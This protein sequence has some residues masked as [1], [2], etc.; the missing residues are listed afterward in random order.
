M[1]ITATF[2]IG[3]L[4]PIAFAQQL[5]DQYAYH[6]SSG[7]EFN[8]NMWGSGSGQGSQC[9]NVEWVNSNGCGWRV[10][11]QWANNRDNVKSYPYSGKQMN[12]KRLVSQ[13]RDIQ[14][15][16]AWSYSGSN[17]RAN[18]AYD[19]FTHSNPNNPTHSGEY[20]LMIWLGRLGDVWPIGR[21]ISTVNVAGRQWQ[22][23]DGY[24]GAMRVYSF[25]APSQV[26]NFQANLK[27]FFDH[28]SANHGYPANNQYLLTVQFG[29]EPFTGGP[30]TLSVSNW[31]ANLFT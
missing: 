25:V 2:L 20:E 6:S 3:L 30:A 16:A 15:T 1:K 18:V 13:W 26:N 29:T 28:L 21:Q 4:A 24:N 23:Y 27:E 17:I 7:Y 8:N 11:W 14:S 12:P 10:N 5:C 22:L 31:N 19:L 9:T